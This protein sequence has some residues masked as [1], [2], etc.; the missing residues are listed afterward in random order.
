M[1]L[2]NLLEIRL[3]QLVIFHLDNQYHE[4][5]RLLVVEINKAVCLDFLGYQVKLEQRELFGPLKLI[6]EEIRP[7]KIYK[8]NLFACTGSSLR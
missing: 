2:L 5:L 3:V 7:F 8:A 1:Q 6:A 4:Y